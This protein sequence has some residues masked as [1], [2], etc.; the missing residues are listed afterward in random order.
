[1]EEFCSSPRLS[2]VDSLSVAVM[3]HVESSAFKSRS[4]SRLQPKVVSQFEAEIY[5]SSRYLTN[6]ESLG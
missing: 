6:I 5:N 3:E 4:R 1:M 2:A